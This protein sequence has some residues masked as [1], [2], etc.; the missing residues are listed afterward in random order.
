MF[1]VSFYTQYEENHTNIQSCASGM[2]WNLSGISASRSGGSNFWR[3][4]QSIELRKPFGIIVFLYWHK[5]HLGW[6]WMVIFH[7]L[8]IHLYGGSWLYVVH[9]TPPKKSFKGWDLTTKCMYL[10]VS[11]VIV[12]L[13]WYDHL[14]VSVFVFTM[15]P[16]QA[17]TNRGWDGRIHIS[18]LLTVQRRVVYL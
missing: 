14:V 6:W 10:Y 5:G 1:T 4:T 7:L 2:N 8:M 16:K 13:Y 15:W 12:Q 9:W 18:L 3:K 11:T 17:W